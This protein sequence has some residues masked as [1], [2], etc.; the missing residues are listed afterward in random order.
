MNDRMEIEIERTIANLR[1]SMP[2]K[3]RKQTTIFTL[4]RVAVSEMNPILLTC[5]LGGIL[6]CGYIFT[7][8]L[9]MPTVTVFC[10]TPLPLLLLFHS[11][12]LRQN[13]AMRELEDTFCYSYAEMLIARC[14][15]ISAYAVLSLVCLCV[16]VHMT[17]FVSIIRLL[18]CGALPTVYLSAALLGAAAKIRSPES[19]S[20]VAIV[21]WV[22]FSFATVCTPLEELLF[23]TSLLTFAVLLCI[24][25]AM[26][27]IGM[28][29]IIR[30]RKYAINII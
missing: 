30:R 14:M 17:S 21:L 10:T 13:E 4:L 12:V 15:V 6:V 27:F 16:V 28:L 8:I 1:S 20:I 25:L 23:H 7:D 26:Y 9:S 11:Y 5:V 22:A 29:Q 19:I 18:L 3:L 2:T 24:G